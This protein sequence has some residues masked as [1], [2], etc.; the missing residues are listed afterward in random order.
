MKQTAVPTK[1]TRR[2]FDANFKRE[3]VA[4]WQNSGKSAQEIATHGRD[5]IGRLMGEQG[6][7][8]RQKKRYRVVTTDSH[9]D[10]PIAPNRLAELPQAS[11]ANQIWVALH[12][13]DGS[14]YGR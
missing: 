2:K 13:P 12:Q 5:R 11:R 9:H 3:A 4:L 14:G 7:C 8:G 1:K 10:Q 6:L